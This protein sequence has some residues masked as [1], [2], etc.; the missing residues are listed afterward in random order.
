MV[1]TPIQD[2]CTTCGA[3][4]SGLRNC[5][6]D[7]LNDCPQCRGPAYTGMGQTGSQGQTGIGSTV[8]SWRRRKRSKRPWE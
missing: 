2:R 4:K 8:E 1:D 7:F 5:T 6:H 3:D